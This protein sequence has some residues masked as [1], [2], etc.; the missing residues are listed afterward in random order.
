MHRLSLSAVVLAT[1][2][3]ALAGC[4][5]DGRW[6]GTLESCSDA[7]LDGTAVS[8]LVTGG[9][10]FV[11]APIGIPSDVD[12]EAITCQSEGAEL[13]DPAALTFSVTHRCS[14]GDVDND[15]ALG[16]GDTTQTG[17]VVIT[18]GDTEVECELTVARASGSADAE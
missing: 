14:S 6:D 11:V 15:F 17:T 7:S 1:S 16:G 3:L 5:A 9:S 2:A 8:I 12:G 18:S 10:A 13:A 4:T